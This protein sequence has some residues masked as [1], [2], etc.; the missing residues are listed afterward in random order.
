MDTEEWD[1]VV[2]GSGAGGLTTAACLGATGKRVLVLER[3]DVAGGNTQVFRRHHGNDWYEFDVGVHYIGECGPGGLLSNIFR[4]LGVG[5]R[6]SF[7][8]LDRDGFDTLHFPDF[9]FRVPASWDDYEAR[10]IDQF[11][12]DSAGIERTLGVLRVVAEQSR[13][14]FGEE[15]EIFDHWAFR[16]LSEL[17]AE[18][19]LSPESIAVIDHWSALYAGGPNQTAVAMHARMI[20][21]YMGGA[22]YPE[23]GGPT[24]A[25][26][27]MQV[28]EA[29]GGEVRTLS[30]V[31]RIIV[32][33]GT[34]TGVELDR[35]EI[36]NAPIVVANGDHRRMI[37]DLIG[38]Q[39]L[40]PATVAW[41]NDATMTLGLVCAYVVVDKELP[42]P[43]TN[44]F[45]FPDYRTDEAYEELDAGR[46]ERDPLS[47]PGVM[48]L[49]VG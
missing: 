4:A 10:L 15:R 20:G 34:A 5:D 18:A 17:F 6:M 9:V 28:I 3:H 44:Y 40:A 25:A 31:S 7:S 24:I 39:H 32:E 23:G 46:I 26:R 29:T 36:V 30:P 33:N 8:E 2:V 1:V 45:L 21:H 16:P 41:A 14:L 47:G 35:G 43:N 38:A 49:G 11:P 12:K 37:T 48:R 42:G 27:L 19:E 13:L 22:Y